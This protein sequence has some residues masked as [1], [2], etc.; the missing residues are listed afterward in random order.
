[1]DKFAESVG[2][3]KSNLA[4][5]IVQE[6]YLSHVHQIVQV[7]GGDDAASASITRQGHTV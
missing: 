2:T 4:D 3:S 7:A 1:M 5:K 6:K